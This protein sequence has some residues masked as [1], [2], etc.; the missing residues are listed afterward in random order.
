MMCIKAAKDSLKDIAY[1]YAMLLITSSIALLWV[2]F[3]LTLVGQGGLVA[4]LVLIIFIG[5]TV[6]ALIAYVAIILVE[7]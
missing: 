4:P 1:L 5:N 7:M 2:G 6:A 3:A